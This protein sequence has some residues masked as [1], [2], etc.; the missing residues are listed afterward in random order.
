MSAT[1][2][3]YTKAKLTVICKPQTFECL[4]ML[5]IY[6]NAKFTVT[7]KPKTLNDYR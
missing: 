3:C 5:F 6:T 1:G 4:L 2:I 7:F